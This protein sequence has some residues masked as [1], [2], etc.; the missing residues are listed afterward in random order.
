M[1]NILLQGSSRH[2]LQYQ[3]AFA[4]EFLRRAEVKI[5]EELDPPLLWLHTTIVPSLLL[6]QPGCLCNTLTFSGLLWLACAS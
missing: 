3:G 2:H 6:R 4:E 1:R 5:M